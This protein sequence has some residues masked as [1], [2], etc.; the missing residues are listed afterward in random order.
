M[1]AVRI[2]SG[3]VAVVR[4]PQPRPR[5]GHALLRLLYGGICNTD[6]ELLRG[7]Y[8]FR[9]TPGHEFVAEVVESP[10]RRWQGK[11]VVGEI[12]LA[13]RRCSWCRAGLMRHCPR[14][15]VLGILKHPG[16]FSEWF[17]LPEVN[18]YEV[19]AAVDTAQAVFTEPLAAACEILEQV[20]IPR[21]SRVAVLGDGKLGLLAAQVLQL[22]GAETHLYGRHR[23]KLA[24]AEAVGV[25]CHLRS[26]PSRA[27]YP[28][29]VEATGTTEGLRQAVN[30]IAPRGTLVLKSTVHGVVELDTAQVVVPEITIVGSRCGPFP[31][32]LR[33]LAS[34]RLNLAPML[35]DE[36]PLEHAPAAFQRAA[37]PG[38]LKVLLRP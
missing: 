31:K 30:V 17:T 32:A 36:F 18:L 34:G 10:S 28:F 24:V 8:A 23:N 25:H 5:P 14:R 35:S 9:G 2:Q 21:S 29:V 38:V 16:A 22:H 37:Q 19:P 1:I 6:L 7:Y 33:L 3:Q 4:R 12:N 15:H 13:C 26:Q 11:R 20:S 27:S